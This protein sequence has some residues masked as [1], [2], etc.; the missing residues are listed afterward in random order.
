MQLISVMIL[1]GQPVC[2]ECCEHFLVD[3]AAVEHRIRVPAQI[4]DGRGRRAVVQEVPVART[5]DDDASMPVLRQ[6]HAH[7]ARVQVEL[8]RLRQPRQRVPD[9][10]CLELQALRSVRSFDDHVAQPA[11]AV[12]RPHRYFGYDLCRGANGTWYATGIFAD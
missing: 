12:S 2:F 4:R 11:G 10:R 1:K 9:E 7:P 3:V 6:E 8:I 5:T